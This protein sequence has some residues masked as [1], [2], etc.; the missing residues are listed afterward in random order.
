MISLGIIEKV[1]YIQQ[2]VK[3]NQK[4]KKNAYK[5]IGSSGFNIHEQTKEVEQS[6]KS[7]LKLKVP[8]NSLLLKRPQPD[9]FLLWF[10]TQIASKV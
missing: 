1:K 9:Q 5:W 10:Q 4:E 6:K 8:P 3:K 2:K 7:E